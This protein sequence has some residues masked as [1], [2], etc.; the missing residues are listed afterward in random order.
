MRPVYLFIAFALQRC[1]NMP[2]KENAFFSTERRFNIIFTK[3]N[4]IKI[5][6]PL[7]LAAWGLY[8][9]LITIDKQE[10]LSYEATNILFFTIFQQKFV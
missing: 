4:I 9:N 8:L 5:K 2:K 1:K 10:Y 3:N 7:A 6:S